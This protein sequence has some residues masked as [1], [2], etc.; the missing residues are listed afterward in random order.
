M[1]GKSGKY[2]YRLVN[3]F[4]GGKRGAPYLIALML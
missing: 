1:G 4:G 2:K 3:G